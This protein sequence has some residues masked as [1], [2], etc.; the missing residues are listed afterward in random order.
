[1]AQTLEE[2]AAAKAEKEAAKTAAKAE[3]EAAF[4]ENGIPQANGQFQVARV[5]GGFR[6]M[7]PTGAWITDVLPEA[8]A[9]DQAAR[10]DKFR[11]ASH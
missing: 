11:Q 5:E 9:N 8:E 10:H 3:K 6:V 7:H 4:A 1:M 2:K